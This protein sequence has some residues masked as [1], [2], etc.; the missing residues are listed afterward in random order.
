MTKQDSPGSLV[1]RRKIKAALAFH[2]V[3]HH[4][5]NVVEPKGKVFVEK[6][7]EVKNGYISTQY[8]VRQITED[9]VEIIAVSGNSQFEMLLH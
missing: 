4:C 5:K 1:S 7:K 2:G 3:L 6:Q 9:G 8:T